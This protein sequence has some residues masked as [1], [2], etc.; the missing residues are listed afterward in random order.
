[1][2]LDNICS[3]WNAWQEGTK[4]KN[5]YEMKFCEIF[6][7]LHLF[8]IIFFNVSLLRVLIGI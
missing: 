7:Y 8:M 2:D 3:G 4:F 6:S 5:Y 1:V